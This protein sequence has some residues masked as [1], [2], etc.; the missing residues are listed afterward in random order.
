[1]LQTDEYIIVIFLMLLFV[2]I[3]I[4]II[5]FYKLTDYINKHSNDDNE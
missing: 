1:M 4:E 2:A 5:L 3:G